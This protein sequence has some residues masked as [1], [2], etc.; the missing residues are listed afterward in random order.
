MGSNYYA[1]LINSVK[2]FE[3][4]LKLEDKKTGH[5]CSCGVKYRNKYL[6]D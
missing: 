6:Q 1:P 4:R 5:D 3:T 2:S